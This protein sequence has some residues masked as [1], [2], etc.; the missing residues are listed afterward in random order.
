MPRWFTLE[1]VK[2][3]KDTFSYIVGPEGYARI[4]ARYAL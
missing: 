3:M 2:R 1:D 4:L